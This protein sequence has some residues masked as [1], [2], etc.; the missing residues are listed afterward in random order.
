MSRIAEVLRRRHGRL[1]AAA[2]MVPRPRREYLRVAG[3]VAED[4]AELRAFR[5]TSR[6]LTSSLKRPFVRPSAFTSPPTGLKIRM[7]RVQF[8]PWPLCRH[9]KF[10]DFEPLGAKA[11]RGTCL[12]ARW[13]FANSVPQQAMTR[14]KTRN[15]LLY[16][17]RNSHLMAERMCFPP[18]T[19]HEEISA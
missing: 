14:D 7:P 4:V 19:I 10:G 16:H 3:H 8:P 1:L 2:A 13:F 18:A 12:H 6:K 15:T 9:G 5:V 11:C 17:Q